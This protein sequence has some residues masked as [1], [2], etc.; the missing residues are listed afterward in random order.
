[1]RRGWRRAL[2]ARIRVAPRGPSLVPNV[3]AAFGGQGAIDMDLKQALNRVASGGLLAR[4]EAREVMARVMGGEATA[5]QLGALLAGLHVRGEDV[6]EIVGFA[7][8]LRTLAVPVRTG[9]EVIDTCGTGGDGSGT[10]NISTAAAI[11]CAAAGAAVAKHGNRA[12]SSACGSADVL[13][14]LGVH[15]DLGAEGVARCVEEVGI[16]FIFAPRFHPA[17]RHAAPVRRELGFRTVFNILGPL[18]NPAAVRRQL[19]GVATARLAPTIAAALSALGASHV[20]VVHGRDGLD[21]ISPSDATDAW[22]IRDGEVL[23][24]VIAPEDFDVPRAPLEEIAGGDIARNRALIEA[25]LDGRPG[26]ARSAVLLNAGAALYVA[27]AAA[28]LREGAQCAADAIDTGA[29][30]RTLAGLVEFSRTLA[31]AQS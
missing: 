30:R 31:E 29:A 23:E 7:E 25:V 18:A 6:A 16:G 22:E 2:G 13:E 11:V 8:A 24:R 12:A 19:L 26:G 14:A 27:G 5:A 15:I 10:F 28:T 3:A 4:E 9:R 21:E 1:M 20:L 17:M